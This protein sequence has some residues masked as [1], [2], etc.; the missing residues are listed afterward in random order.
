[1]R[2]LRCKAQ[3]IHCYQEFETS[4]PSALARPKENF[5]PQIFESSHGASSNPSDQKALRSTCLAAKSLLKPVIPG[6]FRTVRV[7][8]RFHLKQKGLQNKLFQ[9]FLCLK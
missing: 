2:C 1:C 4:K 6:R 8:L 7:F 5:E 9:I 3:N